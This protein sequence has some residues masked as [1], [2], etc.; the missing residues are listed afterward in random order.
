MMSFSSGLL[1]LFVLIT[2]ITSLL[3]YSQLE[4]IAGVVHARWR[5]FTLQ[6]APTRP[7]TWLS[8]ELKQSSSA[9][10]APNTPKLPNVLIIVADDLGFND[11]SD[12]SVDPDFFE[13]RYGANTPNINSIKENGVN[14]AQ[15]YSGHSTCTPS[16]TALFTGRFPTQTGVEFT[17]VPRFF[18]KFATRRRSK[19]APQPVYNKHEEDNVPNLWDNDVIPRHVP[20][21]SD[22]LRHHGYKNYFLGKWDHG[23]GTHRSPLA[24]GFDESLSFQMGA[25]QYLK[26]ND[27]RLVAAKGVAF[28]TLLTSILSFYVQH[29]NGPMFEPDL[30]MTDYLA[31]E[32]SSLIYALGNRSDADADKPWYMHLAFNAPHN[33]FQAL[34]TD[35]EAPELAHI[36]EGLPRIYAA[37]ILALD[38]GVGQVL[39]ALRDSNQHENT[40]V[41]FTSDNGGADYTSLPYVNSPLRGWKLTL[42]EGGIRVPMFLQWPASVAAGQAVNDRPVSHIDLVPTLLHAI[43]QRELEAEDLA[44]DDKALETTFQVK[45][46]GES[47][48]PLIMPTL[49][50][51]RLPY[52]HSFHSSADKK[53]ALFWRSGHYK[54]LRYGDMKLQL[55]G[56]PNKVW[57]FHITQDPR[58]ENNLAETLFGISSNEDLHRYCRDAQHEAHDNEVLFAS[59]DASSVNIVYAFNP[60]TTLTVKAPHP[61]TGPLDAHILSREMC[62]SYAKLVDLDAQQRP[63]LWPALAEIP[64]CIDKTASQSCLLT[65]EYVVIPN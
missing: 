11:L 21:L 4:I 10:P 65:D 64:M 13:T 48:L 22:M 49:P 25:S 53:R 29:N 5:R 56:R 32:A 41:I 2:V 57:F 40:I 52:Y 46:D 30:Y 7:V 42:F 37:M 27:P 35:Y 28:D 17:A 1:L 8:P 39:K 50:N 63:A 24:R 15:S 58:E 3:F 51:C 26:P 54:A 43:R 44:D 38:R 18:S 55:A 59:T 20:I 61:S 23:F 6:I 34:R 12:Y 14:F 60:N 47:L 16:R 9:S 36:P 31:R 45:V 19:D 62:S 33:P